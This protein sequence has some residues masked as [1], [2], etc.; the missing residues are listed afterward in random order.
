ME[1][2]S[3]KKLSCRNH[4]L[5]SVQPH[6]LPW[7]LETFLIPDEAWKKNC[8]EIPESTKSRDQEVLATSFGL[9]SVEF[10]AYHEGAILFCDYTT[11]YRHTKTGALY[12][13]EARSYPN[14][15]IQESEEETSDE[16]ALCV[17]WT[18]LKGILYKFPQELIDNR[19]KHI[20][21]QARLCKLGAQLEGASQACKE[22]AELQEKEGTLPIGIGEVILK[23][24]VLRRPP[25]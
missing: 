2:V 21:A 14:H 9:T 25:G 20:D 7:W 16:D 8:K 22:I 18:E 24:D 3:V 17:Q 19:R 4:H 12:L 15:E 23:T 6:V 11:W 10:L 13:Y 5:G 1:I